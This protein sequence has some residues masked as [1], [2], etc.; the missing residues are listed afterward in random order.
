MFRASVHHVDCD[1][2]NTKLLMEKQTM[3]KVE[4]GS[5]CR[6]VKVWGI[7]NLIHL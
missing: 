4:K 6:K 5:F 3:E 1:T 7:K 2:V